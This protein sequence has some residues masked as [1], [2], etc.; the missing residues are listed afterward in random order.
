[1]GLQPRNSSE[2]IDVSSWNSLPPQLYYFCPFLLPNGEVRRNM[3]S[4][5]CAFF[6]LLSQAVVIVISEFSITDKNKITPRNLSFLIDNILDVIYL[7]PV[8]YLLTYLLRFHVTSICP[9]SCMSLFF[10]RPFKIQGNTQ[11]SLLYSFLYTPFSSSDDLFSYCQNAGFGS[12]VSLTGPFVRVSDHLILLIFS[13][14][15]L[16]SAFLQ[17]LGYISMD[18]QDSVSGLLQIP[19]LHCHF[20]SGF[21][22][23]LLYQ[24]VYPYWLE[25]Q[26]HGFSHCFI[27]KDRT[28]QKAIYNLSVESDEQK[29]FKYL[30]S[31]MLS[32]SYF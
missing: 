14:N 9:R 25:V 19:I 8:L 13:L 17:R 1:M 20:L 28:Y 23:F 15:F 18:V 4:N 16:K 32:L 2:N 12:L 5:C 24:A 7:I 10:M 29:M 26:N 3:E 11:L 30:V 31:L 27:L 21:P 22:S 6:C